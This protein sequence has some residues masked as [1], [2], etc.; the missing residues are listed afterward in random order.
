M[1]GTTTIVVSMRVSS[2]SVFWSIGHLEVDDIKVYFLRTSSFLDQVNTSDQNQS[3]R[4]E[5][6]LL[7]RS[8]E[9]S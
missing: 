3:W 5:Y 2:Q 8:D 7:D 9:L 1:K 6:S 4:V